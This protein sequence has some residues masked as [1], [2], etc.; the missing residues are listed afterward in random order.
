MGSSLV[1]RAFV[2]AKLKGLDLNLQGQGTH[3]VWW[4]GYSGLTIQLLSKKLSLLRRVNGSAPDLLFVHCGGNDLGRHSTVFIMNTLERILITLNRTFPETK[5]VFSQILPRTK[6]RFSNNTKAME[7]AR[8]RI[9]SFMRG[10][11]RL[12]GGCFLNHNIKKCHLDVDGVH[13]ADSGNDLFVRKFS[14]CIS[15]LAAH[16]QLSEI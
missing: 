7:H 5:I 4:Q 2:Y 14:E 15:K 10:K 6:W 3:T 11:T 9:N 16:P 13:L 8:R 1:K 12:F